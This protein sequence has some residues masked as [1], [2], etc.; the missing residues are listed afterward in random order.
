MSVVQKDMLT[1]LD[2]GIP[3]G[4]GFAKSPTHLVPHGDWKNKISLV[5]QLGNWSPGDRMSQMWGNWISASLGGQCIKS[6]GTQRGKS[7]GNLAV[8][9]LVLQFIGG[10]TRCIFLLQHLPSP[11]ALTASS[12]YTYCLHC[13]HRN[14]QGMTG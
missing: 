10:A 14:C 8:G 13:L 4:C 6:K 1:V 5:S 9:S 3:L 12:C 7:C 11:S 2:L